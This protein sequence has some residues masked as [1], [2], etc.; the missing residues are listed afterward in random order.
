MMLLSLLLHT[1][2]FMGYVPGLSPRQVACIPHTHMC[3]YMLLNGC[4]SSFS[5]SLPHPLSPALPLSLPIFLSLSLS[6]GIQV[7]SANGA[8]P[9][10]ISK[11][12]KRERGSS[13]G[14]GA[15][16]CTEGQNRHTSEWLPGPLPDSQGKPELPSQEAHVFQQVG[17]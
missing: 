6:F 4:N 14:T 10:A 8:V 15:G 16:C 11:I 7:P 9:G 1:C 12:S 17:P 3:I 13:S 2:W 5:P